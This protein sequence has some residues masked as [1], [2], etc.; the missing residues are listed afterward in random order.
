MLLICLLPVSILAADG[1]P[2][3]AGDRKLE[4]GKRDFKWPVPGQYHLSSCYL[5]NRDHRSLDVAAPTGSEIVASYD[6]TVIDVFKGCEHNW[7]KKSA[8]CSSWGNYVLLEHSYTLESG[9]KITLYSRYAHMHKISVKVGDR[10]FRGQALGTVGSTGYS[11][12][13]HLDYDILY[14]GTS[15]KYS[16]DPYVNDL[17]ELPVSLYTQFGQCCREYVAYVKKYY[18]TCTHPDYNSE[19]C[20]TKCDYKFDWNATRDAST[21][22]FYTVKATTKAFATPYSQT[23]GVEFKAGQQVSVDA[24]VLNGLEERWYA[25]AFSESQTVYVPRSA[26]EFK[27]HYPSKIKL[28]NCTVING[29]VLPQ[30]SYRLDGQITS[31]YPL[32]KVVGYVDGKKYATWTGDGNDTAISLRGTAL[33]KKLNFASLTPGEHTLAIFVTDSTGAEPYQVNDCTFTIQKAAVTYKITFQGL[34]DGTITVPEDKP[35]GE[36]PVLE[37]EGQE[38]LGWFREDGTPVQKETIPEED[39]V[40]AA[41]WRTMVHTVT[42]DGVTL[43]FSH[44]T[45]IGEDAVP[46]KEGYVFCGWIAGDGREIPLGTQVFQP[47]TLQARWMPLSYILRWDPNGGRLENSQTVVK[48]YGTEYGHLPVPQRKGYLFQGWQLDGQF[49]EESTIFC[50][51]Q[52]VT[53]T[54][55]WKLDPAVIWTWVF[56][57]LA[58]SGIAGVSVLLWKRKIKIPTFSR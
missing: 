31:L 46:V 36:L 10:V 54:A 22:G 55:V 8:C 58:V 7:G 29:T 57:I 19:G 14:G 39:M 41:K 28:D 51:T 52:D 1:K 49:V 44:G 6:G 50:H 21:M 40:L 4:G 11:T 17:L 56:V 33:N 25:V 13:P 48:V 27:K 53:L 43:E 26:L 16:V 47:M 45:P 5:D 37:K 15:K 2:S 20:C 32:R 23:D 12:G 30:A 34:E 42:M 3:Q 18:A 24:T 38:F 35:L 9:K